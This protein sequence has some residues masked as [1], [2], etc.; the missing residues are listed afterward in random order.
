MINLFRQDYRLVFGNFSMFTVAKK[1]F[2]DGDCD[3]A[4]DLA[5]AIALFCI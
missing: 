4:R 2:Y 5:N 1:G 3:L